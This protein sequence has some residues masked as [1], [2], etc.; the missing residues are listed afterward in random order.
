MSKNMTGKS[1]REQREVEEVPKD[2]NWEVRGR[3]TV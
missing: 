1:N 3:W 2:S